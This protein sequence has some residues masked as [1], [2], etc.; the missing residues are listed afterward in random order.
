MDTDDHSLADLDTVW[1]SRAGISTLLVLGFGYYS[2][3]RLR[4]LAASQGV[5]M[6]APQVS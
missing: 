2:R 5:R 4:L 6:V 1:S 3:P